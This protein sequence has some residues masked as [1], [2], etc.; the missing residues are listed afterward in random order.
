LRRLV[1]TALA[2]VLVAMLLMPSFAIAQDATPVVPETPATDVVAAIETITPDVTETPEPTSTPEPEATIE[3][4]V[5]EAPTIEPTVDV[6]S[7]TAETT[8]EATIEP[9]V[10][11]TTIATPEPEMAVLAKPAAIA[12]ASTDGAGC[13]LVSPSNIVTAANPYLTFKCVWPG[14]S[15]RL[16]LESMSKQWTYIV[17]SGT[18]QTPNVNDQNAWQQNLDTCP[19]S[20]SAGAS[21]ASNAF[22]VLLKPMSS[23]PQG[24]QGVITARLIPNTADNLCLNQSSNPAGSVTAQ[25]V[26]YQG[27]TGGV[28]AC[29]QANPQPVTNPVAQPGAVR[30][31]CDPPANSGTVLHVDGLTPGW[32]FQIWAFENG[33][34]RSKMGPQA[35]VGANIQHP[36]GNNNRWLVDLIPDASV[37]TGAQGTIWLRVTSDSSGNNPASAIVTATK[38]GTVQPITAAD[39]T[40]VCTPETA[41]VAIGGQAT[42]TC[43]WS[44][45]ATLG[46]R[47]AVLSSISIPAP[48]GWQIAT[49][50]ANAVVNGQTLTVTP[51]HTIT[52]NAATAFSISFQLTPDCAAA[53][54]ASPFTVSSAMLDGSTSFTGPVRT[55]QV[56]RSANTGSVAVAFLESTDLNWVTAYSF[57]DQ[58]LSG[59]LAYEIVSAAC[60]RW[61][62]QIAATDFVATGPVNG[63]TIP[64]A[65]IAL[66]SLGT[67]ATP[68]IVSSIAGVGTQ[69]QNLGVTVTVPGF[70]AIGTYRSTLTVTAAAGP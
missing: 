15:W 47:S 63:A 1:R 20:R 19:T 29:T 50:A 28:L 44:G 23:V 30:Y 17:Y 52:T 40:L 58:L 66:D 70:T 37:E 64:N 31:Y 12:L 36:N 59:D 2:F 51:N 62:V 14:Q 42:F 22:Y 21:G 56:Q 24:A 39:I 34:W 18:G 26:G 9:T 54:T 4:T 43:T 60:G 6:A 68:L 25:L 49:G 45:A 7:P 48:A 32:K 61:D 41:Q 11:P 33:A 38:G 16:R 10:E 35:D 57:D 69:T 5:T 67:L 55:L 3:P 46:A 8:V 27:Q 65:S 53:T 13:S